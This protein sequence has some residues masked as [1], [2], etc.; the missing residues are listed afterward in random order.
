MRA[1]D[2]G[3]DGQGGRWRRDYS[4]AVL[5]VWR[6]AGMGERRCGDEGVRGDCDVDWLIFAAVIWRTFCLL[7]GIGPIV[8]KMVA[9]CSVWDGL[10]V[11]L[12]AM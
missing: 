6:G 5:M 10:R 9:F 8:F 3:W 7:S 11:W 1:E 4:C 12:D 2:T